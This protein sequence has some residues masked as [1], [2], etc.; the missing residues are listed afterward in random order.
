MLLS[1]KSWIQKILAN[2]WVTKCHFLTNIEAQWLLSFLSI[3]NGP[4]KADFLIFLSD[5]D[6]NNIDWWIRAWFHAKRVS[7]CSLICVQVQFAILSALCSV[8]HLDFCP[9]A[10]L[11]AFLKTSILNF[12]SHLGSSLMYQVGRFST[13]W[14][15]STLEEV[16]KRI[17]K[18]WRDDFVS[19]HLVP[20]SLF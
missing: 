5:S 13:F 3:L 14:F 20:H 16:N 8:K 4:P 7:R 19:P 1:W 10:I 18:H 17:T 9:F 6:L 2:M 11:A 12:A 15:I